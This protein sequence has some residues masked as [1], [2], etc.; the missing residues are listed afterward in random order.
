MSPS[1]L[2]GFLHLS[3]HL[4]RAELVLPHHMLRF[5]PAARVFAH[6]GGGVNIQSSLSYGAKTFVPLLV[7]KTDAS[8]VPRSS[9]ALLFFGFAHAAPFEGPAPLRLH[10]AAVS[11][12][13]P[14]SLQRSGQLCFTDWEGRGVNRCWLYLRFSSLYLVPVFLSLYLKVAD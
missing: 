2:L 10:V 14:V 9:R 6:E 3:R 7:M 1:S 11:G 12:V 4:R 5:S 13:F 8:K